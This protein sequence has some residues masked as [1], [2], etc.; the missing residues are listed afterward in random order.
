Y[1]ARRRGLDASSEAALAESGLQ[2]VLLRFVE[3]SWQR[4]DE[5]LWEV[6]GPPGC[7][8]HSR[9]M[10]WVAFDRAVKAVEKLGGEGP[11]ERWRAVRDEIHRDT[12]ARAFDRSKN[13]FTQSA[14]SPFVDASLLLIPQV[15]FLPIDDPRVTGT[16]A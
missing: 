5:G 15:G 3:E 14:G 8:T 13:A 1:Q 16:V 11:V 2:D 4:P 10:A 6:R 9:V 12:C 7:F